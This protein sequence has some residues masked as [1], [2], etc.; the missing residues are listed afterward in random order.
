[1]PHNNIFQK[2]EFNKKT[3]VVYDPECNQVREHGKLARKILENDMF[4]IQ[5]H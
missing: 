4:M 2:A 3:V 5:N 1:V